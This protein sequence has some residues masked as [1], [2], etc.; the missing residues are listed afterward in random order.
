[1]QNDP[2]SLS[3]IQKKKT[4]SYNLYEYYRYIGLVRIATLSL[5]REIKFYD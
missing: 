3:I 4:V 5:T 1:M 2:K